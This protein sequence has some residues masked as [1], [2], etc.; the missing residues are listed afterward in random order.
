VARLTSALDRM[1]IT[2]YSVMPLAGGRG[3]GGS[4]SAEGQV[5]Q[6]LEM[7]MV[8]CICDSDVSDRITQQVFRYFQLQA[9]FVAVFDVEVLRSAKF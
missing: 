8:I 3:Q 4:W 5:G 7:T 2:G 1:P 9:G 6:A